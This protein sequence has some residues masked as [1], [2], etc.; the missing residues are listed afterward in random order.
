MWYG[1][2]NKIAEYIVQLNLRL[3]N[4]LKEYNHLTENIEDTIMALYH[5]LNCLTEIKIDTEY[6]LNK[7]A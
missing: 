1:N 7:K 2:Y 3:Y 6:K 5:W 4:K